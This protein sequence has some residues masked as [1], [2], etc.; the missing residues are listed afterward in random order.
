MRDR[1]RRAVG[2]EVTQRRARGDARRGRS[3]QGTCR[4]AVTDLQD[5]GGDGGRPCVGVRRRQR[6]GTGA[7]L[8]HGTGATDD[9][10][11]RL[12][13][14][15]IHHQRAVIRDRVG[16]GTT[17]E[18]TRA[19]DPQRAAR[20]GRG[21][22]VGIRA[23]QHHRARVI[24]GGV[25]DQ[26]GLA[27]VRGQIEGARDRQGL[28][29]GDVEDRATALIHRGELGAERRV[30]GDGDRLIQIEEAPDRGD[31]TRAGSEFAAGQGD[32]AE[33][34]GLSGGAVRGELAAGPD[35][36]RGRR[37]SADEGIGTA[38]EGDGAT[39]LDVDAGSLPEAGVT[40]VRATSHRH[41][42]SDF[43][44]T[45]GREVTAQGDR[46]RAAK[47]MLAGA[48]E[49]VARRVVD[50]TA[51]DGA[52]DLVRGAGEIE[53]RPGGHRDRADIRTGGEASGATDA[54]GARIDGEVAGEGIDAG[55]NSQAGA[56]LGEP[57]V[58]AADDP[59]QGELRTRDAERTRSAEGDGPRQAARAGRGRQ[60]PAIERQGLRT[61]DDPAQIERGAARH[62]RARGGG[63]ETGRVSDRQRAG[64]D[65]RGARISIGPA[66][67]L[68]A[69]AELGQGADRARA[70]VGDDAGESRRTGG[71]ESAGCMI[72]D[73]EGE[74]TDASGEADGDIAGAGQGVDTDI[75]FDRGE[76]RARGDVQVRGVIS[77]DLVAVAA[78]REDAALDV[79]HRP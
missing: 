25:E 39:A 61:D 7:G 51:G 47:D 45:R 40:A 43:D 74:R 62:G 46:T 18:R 35:R 59:A 63:A 4:S 53:G 41:G 8:G 67:D 37:A 77:P 21:G 28:A 44:R 55:E 12:V 1:E 54:Q 66:E 5:A 34:E 72:I 22:G 6:R 57:E 49:R 19:T 29:R 32:Q 13:R 30:L 79:D 56:R 14:R 31:R 75:A 58:H 48:A 11:E 20:D 73:A 71:A 15:S 70:G 33:M 23:G 68:G 17:A 69:G 52:K 78:P 76:A 10:R 42:L 3:R 38:G 60:R 16:I 26:P 36:Q 50:V 9:V 2:T 65:G 27:A 24:G 64:G